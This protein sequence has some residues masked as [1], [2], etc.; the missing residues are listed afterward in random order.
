MVVYYKTS[1]ALK[2]LKSCFKQKIKN[3]FHHLMPNACDIF[4]KQ[5]LNPKFSIYLP[6]IKNHKIND[7]TF[8]SL[9]F[10]IFFFGLADFFLDFRKIFLDFIKLFL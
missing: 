10:V 9:D 2:I 8:K 5:N 3:F 6:L 7:L 4:G 1:Y